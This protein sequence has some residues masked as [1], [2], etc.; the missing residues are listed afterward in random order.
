VPQLFR[1]AAERLKPSAP[2]SRRIAKP[3]DADAAG[4]ATFYGCFHKI[5]R[6]EGKRDGHIDLANAALLASAKFNAVDG[7]I[8]SDLATGTAAEIEEER[9]LLYV[10]MT[11][12]K[13]DLHLIVPQRFFTHGQSAQGDRHLYASRTRFIPDGLLGLF[14]KTSWPPVAVGVPPR[15]GTQSVRIN[16]GA[17]LRGMWR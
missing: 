5:G 10:T 4:Q 7:C 2:F 14:D 13:D 9:R 11:R 12:A 15:T 17:R 16:V 3:L 6:E 8:P 1:I